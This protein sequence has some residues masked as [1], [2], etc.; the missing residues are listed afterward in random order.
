MPLDT[1]TLDSD[2]EDIFDGTVDS[3]SASVAGNNWGTAFDTFSKTGVANAVPPVVSGA[4]TTALQSALGAAFTVIPGVPATAAAAV[5]AALDVYW[6]SITF[7]G[8]VG[9]PVPGG[10]AALIA[11]LTTIFA[12]IGGTHA[13]KAAEV[14]AAINVYTNL[15]IVTFPGPLP[16]PVV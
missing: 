6:I 13:S 14:R 5:A 12:T 9:P 4:S 2:L 7:A 3:P 16:F 15:V 11:S 8:A 10:A 1:A